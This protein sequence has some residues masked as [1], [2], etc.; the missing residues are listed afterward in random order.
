MSGAECRC[1][2]GRQRA[3]EREAASARIRAGKCSVFSF[4]NTLFFHVC[5]AGAC[6]RACLCV[7]VCVCLCVCVC[8]GV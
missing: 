1:H 4:L 2:T 7:C 8:C 6:S 3:R 5:F